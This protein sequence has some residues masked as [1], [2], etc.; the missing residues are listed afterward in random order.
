MFLLCGES[1]N[2]TVQRISNAKLLHFLKRLRQSVGKAGTWP[3]KSSRH[4]INK[5]C[6]QRRFREALWSG[7]LIDITLKLGKRLGSSASTVSYDKNVRSLVEPRRW[8][9]VTKA[10]FVNFSASQIVDL[11]MWLLDYLHHIHISHVS[12]QLSCGDTC[13]I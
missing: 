7:Y 5:R 2:V 10:Q 6:N 4:L 9:G 3:M 12:R 11:A 8:A 13:Q 1:P